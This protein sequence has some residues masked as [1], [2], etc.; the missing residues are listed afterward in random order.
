M[1]EAVQY[2]LTL[3]CGPV[4]YGKTTLLSE[5]IP[6]NEHCVTWVSLDEGDND[7]VRF[8]SYFI[9]A[10]QTLDPQLCKSAQL[11]LDTTQNP[12]IESVLSLVINELV[13][14]DYR[15][16]QVIDDYHLVE[17]P[18]IDSSLTFLVEHL[19]PNV[20]LVISSRR[21]PALPLA[22]W[23]ARQ[24][25]AEIR[26]A[27]LRFTREEIGDFLNQA[28]KLDLSDQEIS[29]L[30]ARTEGWIAGLQLAALSIKDRDDRA[31]FITAF[32]GSHR[33]IIDYLVE[34]V[35]S[36]QSESIRD[37]LLSTSILSRL[38]ASLC[39]A[40]TGSG[41]GQ[42]VL[43]RLEQD[44][45]FLVPLDDH[46]NW[47][48]YH[49]LFAEVLQA[50][51]R[52][53]QP[54]IHTKLHLQASE[55][56]ERE[57]FIDQAFRHALAAP[58]LENAACLVERNAIQMI[59][60]SEVLLIRSWLDRLPREMVQSRSRLILAY[61]WI[62][63]LT[64]N[65]QELEQWLAGPQVSA[66]LAATDNPADILGELSLLRAT[67]ARFERDAVRS[68]EYAR[69]ALEYLLEDERG[70]QAGAMYTIGV[71]CLHTGEITS[72]TKAFDEAVLLGETK[73][74]PYMALGSLQELSEIQ[75]KQGKLSQA[76]ETSQ[77]AKRM[78]AR[79]GWQAMPAAGLA[80]IYSGLVLYQVNDLTGAARELSEG[81]E[82][83]QSSIEQYILAQGF[84][85]LA[86]IHQAR[87][88]IKGSFATFRRGLDWFTQMQVSDTGAGIL[89]KLGELQ[90]R[91]GL[92]D[93]HE[94]TQWSQTCHW[95]PEDSALGYLQAVTFVRLRLAQIRR[96]M[97]Q[98]YFW[99]GLEITNRL[100][101]AANAKEWLGHVLEL[102]ILRVLLYQAQG[103]ADRALTELAH[104][105]TMA[106]EENCIR[107][108]VDEGEHLHLLLLDYQGI[109]KKKIV[110]GMQNETLRFLTFTDKLLA[111]FSPST[112]DGQ[113]KKETMLEPLSERE[114]TILR[115]I[116]T[117][118]TNQEIAE[119]LVIAVSTV[120][121]HINHLY[122]KLGT[123][124]RTE[125]VAIAQDLG[126]LSG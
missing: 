75:I 121:S 53:Y 3:V 105:L 19:P 28:M 42:A 114:L 47:Y 60:R 66:A 62:L 99:E 10:L 51:L 8:W 24:Q 37:F 18:A 104:A 88:N 103:D 97:K 23:R 101:E 120:K 17:N 26:S 58:D 126:L 2:P 7:P 87:G 11:V 32:T 100:W 30:E 76:I 33:F 86:R 119:I 59:Q 108:F 112:S 22:R 20:N 65:G 44:N 102:S 73:G 122:G 55:W 49:H 124:T 123:Q 111:A 52:K 96:K 27:D 98:E 35:L 90:L 84:A 48:R 91:I 5:W 38:C 29:A 113:R 117:G 25:I 43:E 68:L 14:L 36:Q 64:G 72:A 79:W 56:Y 39:N 107:V 6:Q 40:L 34:E 116:A 85:A 89:L 61:G 118:R 115:L 74:G 83:L 93:L 109:L 81:I 125:A 15:F 31:G 13:A 94:A 95:L 46:R 50:R 71:A 21:D 12:Q 45:L 70:L 80:H 16:S 110:N 57:G 54:D 9:A 106:E 63:V 67:Q 1:N 92:D 78:A 77:R 4:G 82:L 41:D 69:Q